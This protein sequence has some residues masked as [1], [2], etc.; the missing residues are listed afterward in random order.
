[1]ASPDQSAR[2]EPFLDQTPRLADS[3]WAHASAVIIGHVEIGEHSSVWCGS[4]V[5]GDVNHIRIGD[6]SNVQDNSVLHVSHAHP[7][8]PAG[9]PLVIGND[10]TIGHSCILHGCTIGDRVLVGMGS[11]VMDHAM[12]E[13]DTILGAG[14]LVPEGK[15]LESGWLYLGR[16]A[17]AVRRLT[18]AEKDWL[19]YSARHY[20]KLAATY[21]GSTASSDAP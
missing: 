7:G 3:A 10:V 18:D 9:A 17:K 19:L 15:R 11:L 1:M 8:D 12:L 21:A 20:V 13:P 16:P 4:V 2:I 6:R 14:S 5:R